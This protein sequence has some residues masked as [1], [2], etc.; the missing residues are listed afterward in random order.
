MWVSD[1]NRNYIKQTPNMFCF[2]VQS[3]PGGIKITIEFILVVDIV[4]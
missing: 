1:N 3:S 4:S 2:T